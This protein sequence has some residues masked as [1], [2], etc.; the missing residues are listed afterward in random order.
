MSLHELGVS[1]HVVKHWD[2]V[3]G[4]SFDVH[5]APYLLG[6]TGNQDCDGHNTCEDPPRTGRGKGLEKVYDWSERRNGSPPEVSRAGHWVD[7][8]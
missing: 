4:D 7:L 1:K 5:G 3:N 8:D 2:I 6:G